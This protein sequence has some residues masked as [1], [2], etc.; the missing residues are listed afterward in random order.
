MQE[1]GRTQELPP[2]TWWHLALRPCGLLEGRWVQTEGGFSHSGLTLRVCRL[3]RCR[4]CPQRKQL[5]RAPLP[6]LRGHGSARHAPAGGRGPREGRAQGHCASAP[7][8]AAA[9]Q[10]RVVPSPSVVLWLALVRSLPGAD[11]CACL[12]S[13]LV[14]WV[15]WPQWAELCC[16]LASGLVLRSPHAAVKPAQASTQPGA[17]PWGPSSGQNHR[18]V[19]PKTLAGRQ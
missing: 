4:A 8:P 6:A 13:I 5:R 9:K 10:S 19:S 12:R 1:A 11:A 14:A 16:L 15:L 18:A 7:A 3:S 17:C 2:R